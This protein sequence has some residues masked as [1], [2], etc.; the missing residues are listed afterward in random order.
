MIFCF[1]LELCLSFCFCFF[2]WICV[3]CD[4]FFCCIVDV[5]FVVLLCFVRVLIGVVLWNGFMI[6]EFVW[7]LELWRSWKLWLIFLWFRFGIVEVLWGNVIDSC[8]VFFKYCWCWCSYLSF[9]YWII[10][11]VVCL[12]FCLYLIL[13]CIVRR[14]YCKKWLGSVCCGI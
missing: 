12:F 4:C 10:V 8:C 5:F 9:C 11:V 3:V 7:K 6:S 13:F 14:M 2:F 1:Y